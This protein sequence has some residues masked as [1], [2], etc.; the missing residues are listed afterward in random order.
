MLGR[1][2]GQSLVHHGST[3]VHVLA[4]GRSSACRVSRNVQRTLSKQALAAPCALRAL[5]LRVPRGFSHG[6]S[7]R[8]PVAAAAWFNQQGPEEQIAETVPLTDEDDKL[9]TLKL[10]AKVRESVMQAAENLGG[11]VSPSV[12]PFAVAPY[13][14]NNA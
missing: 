14:S 12:M 1:V 4:F 5:P 11:R 9:E 8:F 10:D 6:R 13:S 2:T 3:D 7:A